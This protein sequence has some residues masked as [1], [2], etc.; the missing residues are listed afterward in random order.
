MRCSMPIL[1]LACAVLAQSPAMAQTCA[2]PLPAGIG[3]NAFATQPGQTAI[4]TAATCDV[5]AFGGNVIHNVAWLRFF[6]LSAGVSYRIET[7]G[8]V[9]F[10]SRVAVLAPCPGSSCA[11]TVC[12]T[13]VTCLAGNDDGSPADGA[14]NITSGI[15]WA[16]RAITPPAT[17]SDLATGW[18]IATGSSAS[19]VQGS[20][21]VR[22]VPQ[23]SSQDGLSCATA[24]ETAASPAGTSVA[25]SNVAV[26]QDAVVPQ[27]CALA[28][29]DDGLVHRAVWFRFTA[30]GDDRVE[31]STCAPAGFDTRLAVFDVTTGCPG[32]FVACSDDDPSCPAD[33]FRSR[34]VIDAV[35][36]RSYAVAVGGHSASAAGT[37]SLT[38]TSGV[39]PPPSC[40]SVTR[41]C[42]EP[43]PR[44]APAPFCADPACC[45]IICQDDPFCCSIDWDATC[46]GHAAAACAPC[47]EA[48]CSPGNEKFGGLVPEGEA[49]GAQE[50]EGCSEFPVLVSPISVGASVAGNFWAEYL[51]PSPGDPFPVRRDQDVYEFTLT[52]TTQVTA[53]LT[54]DGPGMV[55][56]LDDQCPGTVLA[57]S[58]EY[59][60]SCPAEA[61]ACLLPG[62]YRVLAQMSILAGFPCSEAGPANQY[63]LA[64]EGVAC[65]GAAPPNDDCDG[66]T[67]IA[68]EGGTV[69]FD[70]ALA[71]NSEP[72]LPFECD[73]GNGVSIVRDVWFE[74]TPAAGTAR[75]TTCGGG[76]PL[77]GFDT[78][79][80]AYASVGDEPCTTLLV[81]CNDDS[82]ECGFFGS[83]M[84]FP[85][86]GTTTFLVRV[87]GFDSA[88]SGLLTFEVLPPLANDACGG[89]E[90]L[91]FGPP[92][93]SGARTAFAG[94]DTWIATSGPPVLSPTQCGGIIGPPVARDRWYRFTAPL[95]GF[96]DVSTCGSQ[97]DLVFDT[98]IGVYGGSC[99]AAMQPIACNDD[100]AAC[101]N[102]TSSV[103]LSGV[104]AG[105][106]YLVRVGGAFGDAGSATL[107]V[108]CSPAPVV[109]SN[110]RCGDA[111]PLVVDASSGTATVAFDSTVA[112]DD[113]PTAPGGGCAG[114]TI[115]HDIWFRYEPVYG[116]VT[117]VSLCDP[118]TAFDTRLEVWNGCPLQE[119][120]TGAVIAC[121]NDGGSCGSRSELTANLPCGR[122]YYIRVG[123]FSRPIAGGP[124]VLTVI[125]GLIPC[126]E[127]CRPDLDRN[128][129]VDGSDLGLLISAWGPSQ[130]GAEDLD[131]DG[132]VDGADLA[133][134]LVEWGPCN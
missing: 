114:A 22:I 60:P 41:P 56:L 111:V 67:A 118:A 94:A 10:D 30:S 79:L 87:G 122:T 16:S 101:D 32:S 62:T 64:L 120:G 110:D 115:L 1:G 86:D 91:E 57:L 24:F 117:V 12:G 78:R 46:A 75:V 93:G 4:L 8:L 130:G 34:I 37:G 13:P 68:P 21:L 97:G 6:P 85:A 84:V 33:P 38:L 29:L 2:D 76:S 69:A 100:G 132:K 113:A 25:F 133:M 83:V 7:C 109:P 127:T 36:G 131:L 107:E 58:D 108:T 26:T 70:T 43:T 73:E 82:R 88:G 5:S 51:P 96:A 20:G 123:G 106:T 65:D 125:D 48:I 17:A 99:A 40:G 121:N 126:S 74:W 28:P 47:R 103:R 18:L 72:G 27:Q 95:S 35:A 31:A 104:Q 45:E 52:E 61:S 14:C 116:G 59:A 39:A 55:L 23:G 19:G 50:N 90:V 49:C 128:G 124:G 89:A 71:S 53:R 15:P 77:G 63:V 105:A 98:V 119:G 92:D 9:N 102:L 81:G 134:L 112:S 54:S 129:I 3:D 11:L 42:C 44:D 80:A 66:A